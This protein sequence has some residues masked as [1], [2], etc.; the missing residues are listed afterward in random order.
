M[1]STLVQIQSPL[2]FPANTLDVIQVRDN[3][4]GIG[5]EDRLLLC[6]R[7]CTSKIRSIEDLA[8]LGGTF[9]GFRGEALASVAELSSTATV[10]TRIE[11]R[12]RRH[13]LEIRC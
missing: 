7:G 10:T 6:K 11:G 5:V 8:H 1:P 13:G 3:G 4:S 12:G 2:S 9:F